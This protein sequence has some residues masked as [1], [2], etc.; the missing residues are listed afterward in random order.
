M[1][2]G[3][4]DKVSFR[5]E[6]K[7]GMVDFVQG[8][9]EDQSNVSSSTVALER[10][11]QGLAIA[12]SRVRIVFRKAFY[13]S[14]EYFDA[15]DVLHTPDG[16]QHTFPEKEEELSR[17]RQRLSGWVPGSHMIGIHPPF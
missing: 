16:T 10:L 13:L 17:A 15:L 4:F 5:N 9:A 12:G 1:K 2:V 7:E 3:Y 11:M 6:S 14:H 8:P